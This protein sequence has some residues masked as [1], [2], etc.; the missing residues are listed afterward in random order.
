[1]SETTSNEK[2]TGTSNPATGGGVLGPTGGTTATTAGAGDYSK[3]TAERTF[4][5]GKVTSTVKQALA[6]IEE[7]YVTSLAG[8][9]VPVAADTLCIHGDQP[10]AV[11]FAKALRRAFKERTIEVGA[12]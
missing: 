11:A 2:F 9:R 5:V 1:M 7:G 4:A 10:G 3:D 8:K 6:M 12:P